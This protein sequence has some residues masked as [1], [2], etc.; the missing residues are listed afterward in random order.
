[1]PK[2]KSTSA[3]ELRSRLSFAKRDI[4]EDDGYGNVDKT[5]IPQFET[6]ARVRPRLGGE[7]IL[8]ARLAGTNVVM[9][10][11]RY[12]PRTSKVTAD[13]I[14]TDTR[15]GEVYNIHSAVPDERKFFMEML[16][17]KGVVV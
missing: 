6:Q 2:L 13:W 8:A 15:T 5:F 4:A 7:T 10:T 14:A 17:E 9:I 11:V 1:M 16:G 12:S 3:E